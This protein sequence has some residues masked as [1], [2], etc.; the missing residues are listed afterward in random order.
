MSIDKVFTKESL[1]YYLKEL[2]KEFRKRNG[3]KVP[4]EII[5]IGGAAVLANYGFREMTYDID[6]VITASSAMKEAINVV[7]DRLGLPNGWLNTDFKSTSSYSL[8]LAQYSQH[9]RIYSNIL[10]IR[11]V[12]AEYLVAMKLVSGRR[13]KKDLSDIVGIL[14]EQEKSGQ[15]LSYEKI[16]RAVNAL[17]GGWEAISEYSI[18]VLRAAL[19]TDNLSELF[20]KQMQE[21]D[22]A[23]ETV[24][25]I[26]QK[27]PQTVTNSNMNDII[28]QALKRKS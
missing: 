23:K 28:E 24:L 15:P 2:A 6:A 17:Y 20:E 1:D 14:N 10:N 4:A 21:E 25:I 13:Y 19:D 11:T 9:Y 7:G 5:L 18:N 22:E 16:N 12:K 3:T 27:Y 26:K 8:K